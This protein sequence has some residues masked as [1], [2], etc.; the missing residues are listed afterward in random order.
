MSS[1]LQRFTFGSNMDVL[2]FRYGE[3]PF[4]KLSVNGG[5]NKVWLIVIRAVPP[6]P[7]KDDTARSVELENRSG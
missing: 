3:T 4:D 1:P 6:E 2:P 7:V 5:L